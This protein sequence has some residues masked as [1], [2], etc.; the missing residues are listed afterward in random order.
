MDRLEFIKQ[1]GIGTFLTCAGCSL[2]SCGSHEP[3]PVVDFTIDLKD[4]TS[5]AL[6]TIGGTLSKNG[7]LIVQYQAD[8]F[9]AFNQACPHA[10]TAVK[11]QKTSTNFLCPNHQSE[12]DIDGNVTKGPAT[13]GLRKFN[14]ELKVTVDPETKKLRIFS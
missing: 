13:T 9:L 4:P 8:Q 11:Y 6:T 14:T 7:V 2:V 10:G 3:E 5:V 1:L 12:F